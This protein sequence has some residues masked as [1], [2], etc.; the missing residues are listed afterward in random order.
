MPIT[1]GATGASFDVLLAFSLD[2]EANKRVQAGVS[3]M[4]AE[5]KRLQEEAAGVGEKYEESG[6]K[7][8]KTAKETSKELI[9][10]ARIMRREA[11]A[12]TDD[13]RAAQVSALKSISGMIGGISQSALLAG[14]A[15]VGGIFAE[16]SSYVNNAKEATQAT[17][18]WKR[19][20][21]SLSTSRTRVDEV[22][23]KQALPLLQQ[24]AK[25]A[26]QAA[27]FVEK[28][29]EIV[30]A[31]L[32]T[33]VVLAS[34]G[35]VGLAV[36]KGIKLV[37]D[38]SS[39]GLITQQLTAAKLQDVAADKQLAA[40]QLQAGKVPGIPGGAE[41]VPSLLSGIPLLSILAGGAAYSAL[42]RTAAN[43]GAKA[44][45][46]A[47]PE[48][49]WQDLIGKVGESIPFVKK[50]GDA[51]FGT[52]KAAEKA[53]D[54]MS[55]AAGQLAGSAHEAEI[56][57]AFTKWKEDDARLVKEAADNRKKI[58]EEGEKEIA[59]I[60][61]KY[62]D[63]R[64]SINAQFN[65][66]RGDI[67]KTYNEESARAEQEYQQARIDARKG[68]ADQLQKIA[69]DH[70]ARLQEIERDGA[71]RLGELAA[72]RDALGFSKEQDRIERAKQEENQSAKLAA[73]QVRKET[74]ARL[75][76]LANQYAQEQAQRAQKFAQ[77]LA[78]NEAQRQ[79][80][81]KQAA[82]QYQAEIKQQREAQAAKLRDLQEGLNAE[83]IRRREVFIQE[84]K[85]LDASLLGERN[86]KSKYYN[87]M[88]QDAEAWLARYRS[89]LA[90]GTA[91]GIPSSGAPFHDYTGY[92]YSGLYRMAGDGKKQFVL[93]GDAT[94]TA[95]KL[96]GGSLNQDNL[97]RALS[98]GSSKR[99]EYNDYRRMDGPTSK[100]ER[101]ILQRAAE[102]AIMQAIG[103]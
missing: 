11:A 76:E 57:G 63:Q 29:P 5:L 12:I 96:I 88:L 54:D 86:L 103:A 27:A 25:V 59:S 8:K 67:V 4:E 41:K 58:I 72:S 43:F 98:T 44:F 73:Q 7:I 2:A 55:Q 71:E 1:P 33:G 85:D 64:T 39:L 48:K 101:A 70:Q 15:I 47:S 94:S 34:L 81:L 20:T 87:L 80:E 21:D 3:T 61:Q 28:H 36:S 23:A 83:R 93:G 22:L 31:A 90:G 38:V 100:D 42:G 6:E 32:K 49:F 10:E 46:F 18:A 84:V 75:A 17:A 102:L 40:A 74:E 56:V 89:T 69:Q 13:L 62:T 97:L 50:F 9:Q 30:S 92:A 91:S 65:D 53:A 78:D 79:A 37:A 26:N 14:G 24:A 60:T 68:E 16:V 35:A 66:R 82:E 77:D 95:E 51:I 99:V 19:E 52:G 45:G